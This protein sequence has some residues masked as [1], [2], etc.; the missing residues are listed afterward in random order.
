MAMSRSLCAAIALLLWVSAGHAQPGPASDQT[1]DK[2]T[3]LAR[4]RQLMAEQKPQH[5][6]QLLLK[7]ESRFGGNADFDFHLGRAA[8]AAD[9]P[10]E[11]VFA[12]ERALAVKP[13]FPQARAEL[14]R[15]YFYLGENAAARAEFTALQKQ[16]DL[17]PAVQANLQNFLDAID[18]RFDASG[19]RL[20]YYVKT[21]GGNDSNINS[22]PDLTE[23]VIPLFAGLGPAPLNPGSRELES[24]YI[25]LEPGIRFSNPLSAN[26][27]FHASADVNR[28][29]VADADEFSTQ[30]INGVIGLSKLAGSSQ[31]RLA[32]AL[33]SFAVAD[34]V[35]REQA[36]I[37]GEWQQ[38]ID[39]NDR[40]TVFTQYADLSYPDFAFRDG[41]Q[42]SAG[43]SWVH[44]FDS[45][46][47][48]TSVYLGD[49]GV[50]DATRQ[51]LARDFAG[52][53]I[54]GH[55]NWRQH[56]IFANLNFLTSEY[57]AEDTLFLTTRDEDY[58]SLE[59]GLQFFL[60]SIGRVDWRLIPEITLASNK[61]NI[62]V[63]DYERTVF[64]IT[65]RADF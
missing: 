2:T 56:L 40:F 29:E 61:S 4:A 64:G 33:Q 46:V 38:S 19:S 45:G 43:V 28:R 20:E 32:L 9:K 37:S 48:F 62:G 13:D 57:G 52:A 51:F 34:E 15:A 58:Q 36:G 31:Y 26:L 11:A 7:A 6:Y 17:P 44:G 21:G 22:A 27:N 63:Y 8:L 30:T 35:Y 14:G 50:D 18:S 39:A 55:V 3:L 60:T 65:A 5:A 53:R 47:L 59:L 16:R 24:P 25:E 41:D 54:G 49:E 10:A 42:V 1:S 12:L 23:I